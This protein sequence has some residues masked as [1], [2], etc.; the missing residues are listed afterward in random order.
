VSTPHYHVKADF[1]DGGGGDDDLE[2][3]LYQQF[4]REAGF[5]PCYREF[6]LT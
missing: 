3:A 6:I 2:L 5:L 1:S 4:C